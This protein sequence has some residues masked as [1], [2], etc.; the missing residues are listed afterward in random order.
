MKDQVK[1]YFWYKNWFFTQSMA[2]Q[3]PL[4]GTI[5]IL[6][7]LN[8]ADVQTTSLTLYFNSLS[9]T[10]KHVESYYFS[11]QNNLHNL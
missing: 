8:H 3:I 7:S 10:W 2:V 9:G 11:T 1:I 6:M 5:F 4:R